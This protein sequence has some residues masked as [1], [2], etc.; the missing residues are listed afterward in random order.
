[1]K[2]IRIDTAAPPQDA[3][4]PITERRLY[5][6]NLGNGVKL[7]FT[8]ERNALAFQAEAARYATDVLMSAN[9]LL[10]EAFT[11]YRMAWPYFAPGDLLQQHVRDAEQALDRAAQVNGPN[12]V[13]FRWRS[14]A[15][16]LASI[17]TMGLEL[18][19]VYVVKSHAVP[20]HQAQLLAERAGA[21]IQELQTYGAGHDAAVSTS[22]PR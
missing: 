16:A 11:A 20:R 1:M 7:Y 8:S 2:R 12:A 5:T 17:R 9:L 4:G 6:V 13:Y 22:R 3:N 14:M 21:L 19:K 10:S 18:V 15:T